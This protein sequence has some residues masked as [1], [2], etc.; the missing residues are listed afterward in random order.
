MHVTGPAGKDLNDLACGTAEGAITNNGKILVDQ[1]T[2]SLGGD[3]T[4][5]TGKGATF[6]V[7]PGAAVSTDSCCGSKKL[8]FNHGTL[9]VTAPPSGVKSGRPA[10]LDYA[11]LDNS[12]TIS[13]AHG[14]QL[15]LT[16][17][18]TAFEA[19]TAV[20]GAGGTTVIQAPATAAG[21]LNL[22]AGTTFDLDQN[23]SV[24]GIASF[25]GPGTLRWTGGV[26][27]GTVGVA[28][29]HGGLPR[30]RHGY[31]VPS[32]RKSA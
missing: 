7:A 14:Q 8:L 28:G 31:G 24:D 9:Q 6:A 19:G 3:G 10:S 21:T 5:T 17:A 32:G 2:L 23:G 4:V 1:G 25:A 16:G 18:P 15:V 13:V 11:P 22:G 27:S 12:G 29:L 20:T 30:H 26:I